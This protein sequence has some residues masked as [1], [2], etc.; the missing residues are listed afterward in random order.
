[1]GA[2]FSSL[3]EVVREETKVFFKKNIEWLQSA[4]S[5]NNSVPIEEKRY[6]IAIKIVSTVQG[7]MIISQTLVNDSHYK[8]AITD[9][10]D[11]E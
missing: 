11:F 4:L 1:M 2:E 3:P 9:L 10:L 8:K 7:A 6:Q 5:I